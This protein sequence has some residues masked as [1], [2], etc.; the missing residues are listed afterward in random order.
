MRASARRL[1][2]LGAGGAGHQEGFI[3]AAL[4][5]FLAGLF[6]LLRQIGGIS[7]RRDLE[8]GHGFQWGLYHKLFR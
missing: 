4:G 3:G 7:R 2:G 8:P 6:W 1:E 5:F